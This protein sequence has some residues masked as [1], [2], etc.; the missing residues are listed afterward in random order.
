MRFV[1]YIVILA[2]SLHDLKQ[3]L[4]GL[5]DS[6]I[7][8]GLRV[9]LDKTQVIFYEHVTPELIVVVLS[10]LFEIIFT[11]GKLYSLESNNNFER[12]AT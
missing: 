5:V 2:V 9:N 8:I 12:K 3:M 6:S 11:S 4:Y 10:R 1:D 7:R